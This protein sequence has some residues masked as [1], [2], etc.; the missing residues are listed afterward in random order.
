MPIFKGKD[1]EVLPSHRNPKGY[2]NTDEETVFI[3]KMSLLCY[4]CKKKFREFLKGQSTE[5]PKAC[6]KCKIY[7]KDLFRGYGRR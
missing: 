2:T 5:S 4:D 1:G 3:R 7:M 6:E